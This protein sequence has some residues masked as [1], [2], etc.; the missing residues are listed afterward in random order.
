MTKQDWGYYRGGETLTSL[1]SLLA[2]CGLREFLGGPHKSPKVQGTWKLLAGEQ[3]AEGGIFT[4]HNGQGLVNFL[5]GY[6]N[7]S[8][9]N[10]A[11]VL[12]KRLWQENYVKGVC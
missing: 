5:M 12:L 1:P 6:K 4:S 10:L 7:A 11:R 2:E 9:S 8:G 3:E